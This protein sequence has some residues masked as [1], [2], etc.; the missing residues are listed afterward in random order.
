[1]EIESL[2]R[3]FAYIDRTWISGTWKPSRWSVY[4]KKIR[5]NNDCEGLHNRWN[6]K[7]KGR[8]GYY[9]IL[10]VLIQE[11]KRIPITAQQ[12][13]YGCRV[14]EKRAISKKKDE[15]IFQFWDDFNDGKLSSFSLVQKCVNLLKRNFPSFELV[16]QEEPNP[17][18][19]LEYDDF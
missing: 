7:A 17:M 9:W 16:D 3:L 13:T 11:A 1:M 6:R 5:T 14:R 12:L 18:E 8:K 4:Y 15:Q 2:E 19:C 10:S